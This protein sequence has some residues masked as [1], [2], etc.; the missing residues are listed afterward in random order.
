MWCNERAAAA[1][2]PESSLSGN[3]QPADYRFVNTSNQP[4]KISR[5]HGFSRVPDAIDAARARSES[6]CTA[7][8]QD[9]PPDLYRT[10][11]YSCVASVKPPLRRI[12][13]MGHQFVNADW[14]RF[15]PT[16]KV[17]QRKLALT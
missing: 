12:A 14:N 1:I 13:I 2:E 10:D 3:S 16:N 6:A 8:N 9:V 15:S 7:G 4:R 17:N 5:Q 11:A